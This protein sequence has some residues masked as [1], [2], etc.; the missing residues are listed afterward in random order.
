MAWTPIWLDAAWRSEA[1]D[2]IDDQ[3][4]RLGRRRTGE[5]VRLRDAYLEPWT[6]EHSLGALAETVQAALHVGTVGRAFAWRRAL[7]GVPAEARGAHATAAAEW[8]L[9]L[10]EPTVI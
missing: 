6:A 8:L 10:F 4:A 5:L 1:L 2:W 3:L 7:S 9:E